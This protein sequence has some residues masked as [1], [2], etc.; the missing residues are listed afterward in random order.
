[1]W[2]APAVQQRAAGLGVDMPI[3]QAVCAVLAG[4]L[5]PAQALQRLMAREPK[6]EAT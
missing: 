2:S 6:A 1:V 3:T 5:S 4:A